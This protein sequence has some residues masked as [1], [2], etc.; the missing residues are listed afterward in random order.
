MIKARL[1]ILILMFGFGFGLSI[2]GL[3][4]EVS[5]TKNLDSLLEK[6]NLPGVVVLVKKGN[7]IIHYKAHGKVNVKKEELM[8]E[9]AIF[10]IFSMTKPIT[11]FALLQLVD[12][13]KLSLDDNVRKYLPNFEPFEFKG[14]EQRVTLHHLLAHT[15]GMGYGGGLSN[16]SDFRYLISNPLSR[17]NTL[18]DLVDDISG[19][20]LKFV[21]GEKWE[22]SISSDVQ[23]AL[24]EAVSGIPL[25]E[26][27]KTYILEPLKMKD[28]S[29]YVP[30]EKHERLVDM[31]EY[32]AK[33]FEEAHTFNGDKIAFIEKA[34]KS[35]YLKKSVLISG[36]GGL[37]STASDYSNF[38]TMLLNKGSFDGKKLLSEQLVE[39]MTTSHTQGLDMSFL[40]R[41]HPD[42]GFGYGMAVKENSD[43]DTLRN[44]GSYY[45]AGMGGTSFWVDP[46]VDL[47]V[48]AMFQVE[49]GWIALDKWLV[50][51]V[52]KLIE[53]AE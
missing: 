52:Y 4:A 39:R 53:K 33:T 19:I 8:K 30:K 11:A 47:Q 7:E 26:Y 14:Q 27:F 43:T 50:P 37:L 22:Y 13:G 20:D 9:D 35:D 48:I 34:K 41:V 49:D 1:K 17:S 3:A 31:Y 21:P 16:W 15:S 40:P 12:Q 6:H 25:D 24:I 28:T 42:T 44:K 51:E 45:W 29:F 36:G 5:F 18:E 23:G 10:R 2:Y 32:E 38:L 46:K